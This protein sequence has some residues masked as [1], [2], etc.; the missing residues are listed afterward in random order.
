LS[1]VGKFYKEIYVWL[2]MKM[3]GRP[4]YSNF[5]LVKDLWHFLGFRKWKFIFLTILLIISF[6]TALVVPIIIAR[7]IDFFI[8]GN[9]GVGIFYMYLWILLGLGIFGTFL[10]NQTKHSLSL[11]TNEVQKNAKVESFQKVLQGDLVWHDSESTGAKMQKITDGSNMIG[12][13]MDFY[14][15]KGI[16]LVVTIGGVLGVFL[17]LSVKYAFIALLFMVIYLAVEFF[18]NRKLVLKTLEHKR[19][20]ELA[21]GKSYEFSANIGTIKALGIERSS[22]KKIL[23]VEELVLQTKNA[24]KKASTMKWLF[25]QLVASIFSVVFIFWVGMDIFAGVLTI[26][27]IVIYTSY[28]E[29]LRRALS[30]VSGEINT[31]IDV[32][33]GMFRMMEIYRRIPDID[34][35]GARP[36][37]NWSHIRV[38][39]LEFKYKSDMILDNLS[40][41]IGK[42]EKIGIV[43]LSGSGKSTLFKLLL[44]LHLPKKGEIYF[45]NKSV[46]DVTRDSILSRI[47]VVPQETEL[48][49]MSL[50]DNITISGKGRFDSARYKKALLISQ[51]AN[52]IPRMKNGDLTFVG[53][54]G[55]RL[56][57]GEKQRL[58][59][60]RAIY[61]DSDVIILDE[62]TSNLDYVNEG[63]ILNAIDKYL[64]G[65]TLIISAHRLSTLEH[66]DKILFI[67]KGKVVEKGSYEELL[68]KKGK[69]YRL[70]KSQ[71]R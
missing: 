64:K 41:D 25:V 62:S 56:S 54:K 27:S 43:G 66:M 35:S 16:S 48:F 12:A 34:E 23:D 63:K 2:F 21:V 39:N 46:S 18:M 67:E 32:K 52:Y 22:G 3:K 71:K 14:I 61:K 51:V 11:Y 68:K 38:E 53:E 29:A 55:V 45:D 20:K 57:G 13:F 42:G 49:N 44:K 36:L 33:Y 6:A 37:K 40:L 1:T 19:M 30:T 60:A 58:G 15:N 59:I 26:G 28:F 9:S 17:V 4:D 7:I 50:R 10:R 70:W 8:S 47:A 31:L 65:K 24:R 5:E 69:F